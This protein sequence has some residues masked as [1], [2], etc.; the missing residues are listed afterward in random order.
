LIEALAMARLELVN[1]CDVRKLLGLVSPNRDTELTALLDE[2]KP[3]WLL[4][5]ESERILFQAELGQP[6]KIR[7]GLKCSKRLQVHAYAAAVIGSSIGKPKGEREPIL[8]PVDEM[9]TWAVYVDLT[10][11]LS[12]PEVHLPAGH[13][14]RATD[15]KP[16]EH[17]LPK[18]T[19]LNKKLGMRFYKFATASILFHELGHLKF[20]HTYQEG[21]PSLL[22]EKEADRFAAEWMKEA[23]A[24]ASDDERDFDRYCTL[25]GTAVAYLWLTIFNVFFGRKESNTHPEGYDRLFQVLDHV[26]DRSDED[27]YE[28][29]WQFIATMLFIHMDSAD[30]DFDESGAIHMQGDPRD[31]V[32]YLID[33]ISRFERKKQDHV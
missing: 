25:F 30:Y 24:D 26:I 15:K 20:G 16:P 5:R 31:E 32:N 27:E 29:V 4:D 14:L 33:R 22:Q 23:A 19:K 10:R 3:V 28:A 8:A 13:V 11:W 17:V 6:N 9:L 7:M 2:L 21:L 1:D 18:L 12:S